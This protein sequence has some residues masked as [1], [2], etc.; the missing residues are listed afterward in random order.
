MTHCE[1]HAFQACLSA[2]RENLLG[3]AQVLTLSKQALDAPPSLGLLQH[4]L[5]VICDELNL[6]DRQVRRVTWT[7]VITFL[8]NVCIALAGGREWMAILLTTA[9]TRRASRI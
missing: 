6:C 3:S 8:G 2:S 7:R 1:D 4:I 9:T 5:S